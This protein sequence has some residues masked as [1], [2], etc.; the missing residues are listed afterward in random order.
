MPEHTIDL[1]H[2]RAADCGL[3][4][5]G[6]IVETR[7]RAGMKRFGRDHH[8]TADTDWL[9]EALAAVGAEVVGVYCLAMTERTEGRLAAERERLAMKR[10]QRAARS[11]NESRRAQTETRQ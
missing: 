5:F 11:A 10:R 7:M 9:A 1:I 6:D 3:P 4:A 2:R 8:L